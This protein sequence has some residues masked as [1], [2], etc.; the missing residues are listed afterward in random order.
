MM[1]TDRLPKPCLSLLLLLAVLMASALGE[2]AGRDAT[3]ANS[4]SF[5][6]SPSPQPHPAQPRPLSPTALYEPILHHLGFHALASAVPSL[7]DSP[8]FSAWNG[9]STIFAATDSSLSSS[10][11][12]TASSLAPCSVPQILSEYIVP[13]LFSFSYLLSL[14]SPSLLP[15]MSPS[16]CLL[17]TNSSATAG[18]AGGNH[19]GF[20]PAVRIFINGIEITHPDMF[21]NGIVV[22]HGIDG[23]VSHL[24][25]FSC[26]RNH[27]R[28]SAPSLGSSA[29][30]TSSV[31]GLPENH[32]LHPAINSA[33]PSPLMRLMLRDAILRLRSSGFGVLA[34]A[35]KLKYAELAALE[36]VTIFALSDIEIFGGSH[37]YIGDMWFHIV[38]NTFL[39][40]ADLEDLTQGTALPTLA[41]GEY[42]VV[43]IAGGRGGLEKMRINYMRIKAPEIV[44]NQK[45]VV[46]LLFFSFP[47][48][49]PATVRELILGSQQADA[50]SQSIETAAASDGAI[51][52]HTERRMTEQDAYSCPASLD[53]GDALGGNCNL[54]LSVME[55]FH[56]L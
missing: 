26:S 24:S 39:E 47:H 21:D 8:S 4:F 22:V 19:N 17:V 49:H 43:T 7:T 9:P 23:F 14:P 29:S 38:P 51:A 11:L 2:D 44:K 15:S 31:S 40:T 12:S 50:D 18:L 30:V 34:L 45:V 52:N 20:S 36:K 16:L 41:R 46:H 55:D 37:S 42:L 33:S 13:G 6:P 1:T 3:F 54:M 32:P 25:P 48:L 28:L 35:M 56:G 5:P 10:C 53:E 27:H